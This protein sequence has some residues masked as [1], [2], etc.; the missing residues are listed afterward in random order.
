MIP[1]IYQWLT[2]ITHCW[3][4]RWISHSQ[5]SCFQ[6]KILYTVLLLTHNYVL[7]EHRF[8]GLDLIQSAWGNMDRGSWHCSGDRDQD[9]L[10]GKEM[11]KSKMAV[12]GGLTNNWKEEKWKAKNKRKDTSIWMQS[13]KEEQGEIRKPPSV[14][15]ARKQRKTTEWERLEISS[16]KLEIPREH[17][18]QR[19]AQ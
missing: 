14:I 11:Q 7:G 6:F 12:W 2:G 9:H 3:M 19:W 10:H 1:Y 17:F 15:N 4:N 5:P 13:S 18:M 8:K 16:R